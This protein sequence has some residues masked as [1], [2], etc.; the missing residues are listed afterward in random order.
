VFSI[1]L[2]AR[3]V[4]ERMAQ[5][6]QFR[7]VVAEQRDLRITVGTSGTVEPCEIVEVGAAVTGRILQFGEDL[8]DPDRPIDVGSHVRQ[9]TVLVKL[10][11]DLYEVAR[12]KAQAALA[13]ADAELRLL[14]TQLDQAAR[15]LQRAERLRETNSESDFDKVRTAYETA[16]SKLEIG[17]VQRTQAKAEARHAELSLAKTVIR[18]PIDGVVVDRRANVGQNVLPAGPALFL[19]AKDLENMRIR[20]SVSETDIGKIYLGQPVSFTV[21]AYR[22]QTM[23]GHVERIQLNARM[24]G[25]FVTYDVLVATDDAE[26]ELLPHMTADVEFEVIHREDAWLVPTGSLKWWPQPE[27]LPPSLA[28]LERPALPADAS[29]FQEG[30]A[31]ILWLPAGR[32]FVRPL[33]VRIGVDDGVM[34]EVSGDGLRENLPVVVGNV[35]RTTLARI[36]PSAKTVR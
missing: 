11:S 27:Q 3:Y 33:P 24:Q 1:A 6:A 14:Q 23:S 16:R 35:K 17:R 4:S 36:I 30:Q 20:A 28:E 2:A 21:D 12:E 15:N 25:N 26:V 8:A 32:G 29:P 18:S 7:T 22:E 5:P 10:E 34:T 19:I 31:G 13:L 9:G